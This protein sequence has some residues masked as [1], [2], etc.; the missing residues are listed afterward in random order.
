MERL[1]NLK[2][3]LTCRAEK[4]GGL[5]LIFS[6]KIGSMRENEQV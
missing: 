2:C 6:A 1:I 4:R 5:I 3:I